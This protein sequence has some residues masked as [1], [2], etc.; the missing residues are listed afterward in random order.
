MKK[1]RLLFLVGLLC[2]A[3]TLYAQLRVTGKVTGENNMPLAG[4]TVNVKSTNTNVFT[5][6][7]GNFTISVP[8]NSILV[9]SYAGYQTVERVIDNANA[10]EITIELRPSTAALTEVVVTGYTSQT[11]RQFTG[12]VSKVSGSEVALQPIASF[13]QLLQGQSPGLLVQSQSG[14]PG[15]AAS[16]TIRGKGSVLGGTQPLYIVDGIQITAADFQGIN[17]A[18][19]ET[20]NVLKDAVSTSQYGSRGAN[21]VIVI[22][23]RR[24]QNAKTRIN[25]DFQYGVQALPEN[26]LK[27]MNAAQHLDYELN[28]DRPDGMNPFGWS[29]ADV[30]SLSK[31][32]PDWGKEIFRNAQTQ[33][34]VLSATGGND[35]TRFFLSGSVFR[36]DGLVK[37][38][39][40][41]RYT[42]RANIDHTAG[43][44]RIGLS[45]SVGYST[46]SGTEE[47]D[48]VIT[49][50]L[51][52]FRWVLPYSSPYNPDGS[53]NLDDPGFNPNPLPDLLL[54]IN[55]KKQIKA[56][57]SVSLDYRIA[58][59]RGLSV[60][61]LWGVDFTDDRNENYVD[62]NSYTNSVVPGR[63]GSF[64]A[65]SLR[66]TRVTGTTSL[67]YE[68][69]IGEHNFGGGL[70]LES[71]KRLTTTDGFT[72]YGLIGPLKNA[73]GITAGTPTNNFI[74]R[75][76]GGQTEEAIISY[77]FIGNYDYKGRYFANLT[78]R[79]DGS[80]RLA[81]GFKFVN[82][83]G[84]GLGWLITAEE[85]MRAQRVFNNLKL[86]GSFGS[87]G[88]SNIGDSYE[89][90]EQ[91]I[92]VSYNGVAGLR[93]ENL[94]KPG[95]TW[96]TRQT[97]NVGVEFTMLNNRLTG[98]VEAYNSNT[99]GLYL[100]RQLSSTNGVGSILTNMG[101]LRNQGLEIALGYDVIKGR[102]LTW[103]INANWSGNKSTIVEL[104]G[105][106]ENIQGISINRVG[107]RLNSIYLVRYA[108][109]NPNNGE[110]QYV[111]KDGK[112]TETYDPNDAVIAGQ[113]DPKGFGG[114]GTTLTVK[115]F[116]LSALFTYQ[117]GHK[118]F[119]Q[120]RVDVE[121]P[122]YYYS[123]L[124]VAVLRE[125]KQ[126]GDVT[127]IPSAFSD[128]QSSTRFL[129][130]GNFLRFRNVMLSY[131]FPK[132][133]TDRLKLTGIRVFV[134][135]QNLV[136]WHN[137]QG[138]DPEVSSGTLTGAQ[139]P[140]LR[141][142]TGGISI[143]L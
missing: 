97:A 118:I 18:D 47:N 108:G 55:R 131:S 58:A 8:A 111:T 51:N 96:E 57:G 30:D 113:F 104:D 9:V 125:W 86:K 135:G 24:G 66:R 46:L 105:N 59:V 25:Y 140:A 3:Q 35:K 53:F 19:I 116:E 85:F 73:A 121:N 13:E 11:R 14:Q 69:R 88:N 126:P 68:K 65:N 142:V 61:T 44:L 33:Q 31:L 83:G 123:G 95:L 124:S 115:G 119:N 129:E 37:T 132:T 74:P 7:A 139:Y 45:T 133:I 94:K 2:A 10:A 102:N 71:V 49:T 99:N 41:D 77:F 103:N 110:A 143:G 20:Y 42:G 15:S 106:E 38:T 23:T 43:N 40:L 48:N 56:I 82:Y 36:Q 34:H 67:N 5:D 91:F 92:P 52:A 78:G 109:V 128:I 76:E 63:A 127:D 134:Q 137:F 64:N 26:K 72:G 90:L 120:A 6:E 60:R 1:L 29:P 141:A 80:S 136:T 17:P 87:S 100:N 101:K 12:S 130:S 112:I 39:V 16:V 50:P 107:E 75:V 4:A 54:N 98:S 32:N 117:Y 28:Y 81:P 70:F 114:F 89:A 138:F 122:Q 84:I 21:G 22:T 79:R 93:L 62:V 27:L